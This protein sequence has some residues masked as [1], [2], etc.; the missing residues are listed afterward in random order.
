MLDRQNVTRQAIDWMTDGEVSWHG[1]DLEYD[2]AVIGEEQFRMPAGREQLRNMLV[3]KFPDEVSAIDGFFAAVSRQQASAGLFFV[4]RILESFLPRCLHPWLSGLTAAHMRE[5]DATTLEVLQGLGCSK[6]LLGCI[7]YCFGNM[8]L[9]PGEL[10][11][12]AF[13]MMRNHF[14]PGGCYPVGG[15][16]QIARGYCK[17]IAREGGQVFVKAPVSDILVEHDRA[18]GVRMQSGLEV[19]ARVGVVSTVGARTTFFKLLPRS[20]S[21]VEYALQQLASIPP[22]V[23]HL[24]LFVILREQELPAA[25]WWCCASFDHDGARAAHAADESAPLP[26]VFIS[27]PSAKDPTWSARYPGVSTCHIVADGPQLKRF[28]KWQHLDVKQRGA[29]YEELKSTL[30]ERLLD[31][32]Y[33]EFPQLKGQVLYHELGTA[34]S[35]QHYLGAPDGESYG[36]AHTPHR[37]RC[38]VLR[39]GTAVRGLWLAGQDNISCGVLAGFVSGYLT[40]MVVKPSLV[41]PH[42]PWLM[43]L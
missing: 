42:L 23:Q 41:V 28:E 11:F 32:L 4:A 19:R 36:L 27:F 24:Q 2:R 12:A 31:I 34:L 25:N 7:T 38:G 17:A 1:M 15:S 13:A 22:S 35:C 3:E 9:S 39:P 16:G 33:R 18:V 40:A 29:D 6:R 10:S 30:S 43:S 20:A 37:Y 5:S 21:G 8:G 26:A 14:F